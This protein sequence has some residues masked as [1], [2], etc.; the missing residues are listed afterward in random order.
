MKRLSKYLCSINKPEFQPGP[1]S[2][3]LKYEM[4][5]KLFENKQSKLMP[6]ISISLVSVLTIMLTMLILKPNTAYKINSFVF[7]NKKDID[8]LLFNSQDGGDFSGISDH[9]KPVSANIQG[10]PL[11]MIE[12]DKSY[13]LHKLR[14][15]SNRT[16][17]YISE[18]KQKV[19]PRILY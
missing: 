18:V 13:I 16:I 17:F 15:S 5:N 8:Y 6:V 11:S 19:Q 2:V 4:R 14:D 7:D 10:S 1:F 9:I 12:E 3:R